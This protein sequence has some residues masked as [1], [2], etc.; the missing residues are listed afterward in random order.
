MTNRELL[1]A[2]YFHRAIRTVSHDSQRRNP[3]KPPT[4]GPLVDDAHM[5]HWYALQEAGISPTRAGE[6]CA[7]IT[8]TRLPR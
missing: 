5:R 6:L 3:D 4:L 1:R 8:R 2:M 7:A